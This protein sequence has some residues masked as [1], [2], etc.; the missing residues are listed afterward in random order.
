MN[1]NNNNLNNQQINNQ[2]SNS[3][4]ISNGQSIN[5]TQNTNMNFD[6]QTGKPINQGNVYNNT[7]NVSMNFDPQTGKPI[8]QGNM[9][10]NM[11]VQ[12]ATF[13]DRLVAYLKDCL[14]SWW[15]APLTFFGFLIIKLIL[16]SINFGNQDFINIIGVLQISA[17]IL[18]ILYNQPLYSM[19]GEVSNRHATKGKFKKNICVLDKNG[20]YLD[21]TQS[22]LRMILKFITLVFP[23]ILIITIITMLCTRK[24]Q[25]LHDLILGHVVVR[26][27]DKLNINSVPQDKTTVILIFILAVIIFVVVESYLII[28]ALG[29]Y[30]YDMLICE[31]D[32]GNITLM[33][34]E[35]E[36]NG[37]SSYGISYDFD[38][39]KDIAEKMGINNYINQFKIWFETETTGTCR[40]VKHE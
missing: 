5:N 7:Q 1:Q 4:L 26:D 14:Y 36:L 22:T 30:N 27:A 16:Q 32:R 37:Y 17:P 40:V 33:Y 15:I 38:D 9:Y 8:N 29:G 24:K 10:N 25:G 39:Q 31:S 2:N 28:T 18:F 6:P 12:Y 11:N 21:I 23:L 3:S 19:L 13:G 34:G 35:S 20:N